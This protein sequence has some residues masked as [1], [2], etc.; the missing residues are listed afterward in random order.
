M[1]VETKGANINN[2]NGRWG[3]TPLHHAASAAHL[4]EFLELLSLKAD[5]N[6]KDK[7]GNTPLDNGPIY[8]HPTLKAYIK[9]HRKSAKILHSSTP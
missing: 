2:T 8:I 5:P 6:I 9:M 1:L 4:N 3:S 7:S